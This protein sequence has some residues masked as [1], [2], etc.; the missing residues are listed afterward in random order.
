MK[1]TLIFF[2]QLF[3]ICFTLQSQLLHVPQN[4]GTIQEAINAAVDNDTV[5][6]APGEYFE[7]INFS[8]KN[9][10]VCSNFAVTNDPDDV[11]S[12]IIN[13]STPI[14]EDT[15]SC[16]LIV[17]GEDSTAVLQGF[18]LTG[19]TGTRWEDEH[20][21]YHWYTEGGGILIQYSAPTIKNNI[22]SGNE[23]INKPVGVT[24]AGGGGIRCGDGNPHILNNVISYNQGRYGGGIVMNYSGAVIKNNIIFGNSGGSDF[25]G[26]GLWLLSNGDEPLILI[27]NTIVNN[28]SSMGGGGIRQLS[29]STTII[30]NI[31]WGNTASYQPQIQGG[32]NID[33]CCIEGGSYGV[34]NIDVDPDFTPISFILSGDSPCI[35]AGNPDDTYNDPENPLDPGYALYPAQGTLH[36]D[37]GAYGG[38]GC[39][40]LPDIVTT[41]HE[42]IFN[43]KA[44]EINVFP[45]PA[46]SSI[47]I[48]IATNHEEIIG[49]QICNSQSVCVKQII[50]K[51]VIKD[52]IIVVSDITDLSSGIYFLR[53]K[54]KNGIE[55]HKFIKTK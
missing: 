11:S 49:I 13:G 18:T 34:G 39:L 16:V 14:H 24:S 44:I 36:S 30:N 8:G 1:S 54:S 3:L 45:N 47:S 19:G 37:I 48:D 53:I 35:D 41:I 6:V 26:G 43:T 52:E 2:A 50:D 28:A 5:M 31:I 32:G 33:Y 51:L 10:V 25:G 42:P 38:P 12:T 4:Y 21:V 7:N 15:A 20:N 17:S 27:N 29:N 40:Q 55:V 23:A 9:I 46:T 22:I